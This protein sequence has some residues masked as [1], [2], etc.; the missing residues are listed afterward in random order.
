MRSSLLAAAVAFLAISCGSST[1]EST[2]GTGDTGVADSST[3]TDSST[4]SDTGSATD[5][6]ASTDSSSADSSTTDS[7]SSTD[8]GSTDAVPDGAGA[9]CGGI[10][11]KPCP[12]GFFC[13]SSA[14]MCMVA[15]AGG[16]CVAVP[17]SCGK[18]LAPVCGCDGKTYDNPCL[19]QKAKVSVDHTG[20]CATAGKTCG[21]KLGGTCAA[22]DFCDY[23]VGAMCGAADASGIST[24]R[25]DI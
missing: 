3:T 11:G 14:G 24:A 22:T 9:F 23:P 25:P 16:T 17:S 12:T 18:D 10:A 2:T 20:S 13:Q 19:A 15:D 1:D 21:G 8:S 6:G 7:G 4:E 5:S